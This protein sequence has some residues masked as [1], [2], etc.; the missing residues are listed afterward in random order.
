M[1]E[2]NKKGADIDHSDTVSFKICY[3]LLH[4]P[5]PSET[6]IINEILALQSVG[7]DVYTVAL[8][9][10]QACHE[11]LMARIENPIYNISDDIVLQKAANNS[12]YP[13]ACSLAEHYKVAPA[14]AAKAAIAAE[15]VQSC[16]VNHIHA[17]F[18]TE[19]ALVA[20]LVSKLTKISY[21]FTAHA[22]DIFMRNIAGETYPDRRLKLLAENA[23][24]IITISEFNREHILAIAG[25]SVAEKLE[26]VHCGIDLERFIAVERKVSETVTFLSVGRLI[27]KKGHELLLRSFKL[28]VE[29]CDARL[30][31]VGEGEL[32]PS[33]TALAIK[34]D[35]ADRVTFIGALSNNSVL[36]E[37]QNADVF[38]LH[39][40]VGDDGNKEGIPVSIMEACATALPV[41]STRH[42]GIP[43]L[44]TDGVSGFLVDER[45]CDGFAEAMRILAESPGLR[46]RMG[47]AGHKV[48]SE[49]FNSYNEAQKLKVIF[50]DLIVKS[51]TKSIKITQ[52]AIKYDNNSSY[53]RFKIYLLKLKI[54]KFIRLL[55]SI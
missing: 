17:H 49:Y 15:Y 14:L 13:D 47:L 5:V 26:V 38:V 50:T 2:Y 53:Y 35:L 37:M 19:A 44:I 27:A 11:E 32:L 46:S 42:A 48:V 29:T 8:L 45:D 51:L 10:P 54:K 9:P 55:F 52:D 39:S 12:F 41:V 31:I 1:L 34:L 7:F 24:K 3:I 33:L 40:L 23:A 36:Q 30:R 25:Q 22:Y 16:N 18:A 28:L 21:S 6:F 20:L 43:E 4:I